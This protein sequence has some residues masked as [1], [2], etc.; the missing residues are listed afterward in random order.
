VSLDIVHLR[1]SSTDTC[2]IVSWSIDG[3]RIKNSSEYLKKVEAEQA[4]LLLELEIV[5]AEAEELSNLERIAPGEIVGELL[6]S[7]ISEELEDISTRITVIEKEIEKG[8][9]KFEKAPEHQI[10]YSWHTVRL[11]ESEELDGSLDSYLSIGEDL[12]RANYRLLIG[13]ITLALPLFEEACIQLKNS[14]GADAFLASEGLLRCQV[15]LGNVNQSLLP[16]LLTLKHYENNE[17]SPFPTL[18]PILDKETLLC[19]YLPPVWSTLFIKNTLSTFSGSQPKLNEITAVLLKGSTAK[20]QSFH[21]AHFLQTMYILMDPVHPKYRETRK[22][23]DESKELV[24]WKLAWATYSTAIG[25]L[26]QEQEQD[27]AMLKL[28]DVAS[29]YGKLNPWIAGAAM[30][31]L[32]DQLDEQGLTKASANVR[33]EMKRVFPNHPQFRQSTRRTH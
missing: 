15:A 13:D 25:L 33:A 4:E 9:E 18:A 28:A 6:S 31:T 10:V 7:E 1:D 21:G 5:K 22:E 23:L 14:D 32:A 19:P 16:W 26:K 17:S 30:A 29:T 20:A 27:A 2:S 24:T 12:W 11:V 3:L 8:K